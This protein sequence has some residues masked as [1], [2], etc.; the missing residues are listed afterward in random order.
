M[1]GEAASEDG[2]SSCHRDVGFEISFGRQ[3]IGFADEKSHLP[4]HRY[5]RKL[6][7]GEVETVGEGE[8]K[9]DGVEVNELGSCLRVE[10]VR[11][12]LGIEDGMC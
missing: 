4:E 6:D 12:G 1:F 3:A 11:E 10:S 9:R 2:P 8:E 5:Q 7:L